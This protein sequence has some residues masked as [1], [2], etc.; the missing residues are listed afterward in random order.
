MGFGFDGPVLDDARKEMKGKRETVFRRRRE[1]EK[2]SKRAGTR[3]I[4]FRTDYVQYI[5]NDTFF[6][7]SH[8][9][10]L[11]SFLESDL[12]P[13]LLRTVQTFPPRY[14][15]QTTQHHDRIY[16]VSP[17]PRFHARRAPQHQFKSGQEEVCVASNAAARGTTRPL[18]TSSGGGHIRRNCA[19]RVRNHPLGDRRG[20]Y[21]CHHHSFK[22][23]RGTYMQLHYTTLH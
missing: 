3:A 4:D 18:G 23:R 15:T 13:C 20:V 5:K 16:R 21:R 14:P 10:H 9:A 7:I 1:I 19:G 6:S 8:L 12:L 2:G 11:I 17:F 22:L